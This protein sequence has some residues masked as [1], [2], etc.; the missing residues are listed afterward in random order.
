MSAAK[1]KD[2]GSLPEFTYTLVEREDALRTILKGNEEEILTAG[3][4]KQRWCTYLEATLGNVP[5]VAIAKSPTEP[6]G[7]SI[8]D[9]TK[10]DFLDFEAEVE[11]IVDDADQ[12]TEVLTAHL[13]NIFPL[14]IGTENEAKDE[15]A[16]KALDHFR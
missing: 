8:V 10:I 3:H 14:S 9:V 4:I 13:M 12:K 2:I 15:T 7:G 1:P 5:W 16:A 6:N 11:P